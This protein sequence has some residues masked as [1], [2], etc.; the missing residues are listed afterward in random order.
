VRPKRIVIEVT[1]ATGSEIVR[2]L[3]STIETRREIDLK[4]LPI[5]R[6]W[7]HA[8][9]TPGGG[10]TAKQLAV[11]GIAWPP[12]KGWLTALTHGRMSERQKEQFESLWAARQHRRED[13]QR[14][15]AADGA[16]HVRRQWVANVQHLIEVDDRQPFTPDLRPRLVKRGQA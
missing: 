1:T 15:S 4:T 3:P 13:G 11:F 10:W 6:T 16:K 14:Q 8:Y 9:S 2:A 12:R 5:S 7:L